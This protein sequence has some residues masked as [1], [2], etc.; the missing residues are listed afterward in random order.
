M[1]KAGRTSGGLQRRVQPLRRDVQVVRNGHRPRGVLRLADDNQ[2]LRAEDAVR[3]H[4]GIVGTEAGVVANDAVRRHPES[5]ERAP[6]LPRLIVGT[7]TVIPGND[8]AAHLAAAP[9]LRRRLHAPREVEIRPP[10]PQVARATQ[11]Q[12]HPARRA[13][14]RPRCRL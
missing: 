5:H 12:P 9:E 1:A 3:P 2:L 13:V 10:R 6:H 4:H 7:E 8:E 14:L 11:H